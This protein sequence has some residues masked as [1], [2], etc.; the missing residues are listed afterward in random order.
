MPYQ[1]QVTIY[2]SAGEVVRTLFNG[3]AAT[4]PGAVKLSTASLMAGQGSLTVDLGGPLNGGNGV[5]GTAAGLLVW[6][7]DNDNGQLVAGGVYTM[8][9]EYQDRFGGVTSYTQSIN[10][11]QGAATASVNVYNS[12]G[13]LVY[14]KVYNSV[15]TTPMSL[16]LANTVMAA[17]YDGSGGGLGAIQ[18]S[19]KMAGGPDQAFAWDGRGS[20][21]QPVQ[22]GVYT[23]QLVSGTGRGTIIDS[24]QISVIKAPPGALSVEPVVGPNPA[25][26]LAAEIAVSY[27]P[28]GLFSAE[29]TL[30]D[31]AG[32]RVESAIDPSQSGVLRLAL[33][34]CA[35]GVYLVELR[36]RRAQGEPYRKVFKAAI[37]R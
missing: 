21:G 18:G 30:Y 9:L 19:L 31:Q 11:L 34:R 32:E 35:G 26:P 1:L 29:A 15:S 37:L 3:Q 33:G 7:A 13:E 2:N 20:N 22:P 24:R 8:K 36:A 12:A 17:A 4:L 10:V 6:G 5:G 23:L 14:A 16:D 25:G 28:T 27:P